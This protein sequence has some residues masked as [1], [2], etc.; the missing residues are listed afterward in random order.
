MPRPGTSPCPNAARVGAAETCAS[1]PLNATDTLPVLFNDSDGTVREKAARAMRRLRE[2]PEDEL[3][4]FIGTFVSSSAFSEHCEYLLDSLE[5]MTTLLPATA[6]AACVPLT[7][8]MHARCRRRR[9]WQHH[10]GPKPR[11]AGPDRNHPSPVSPRR[12][13]SSRPLP[14]RDRPAQRQQRVWARGRARTGALRSSSQWGGV[15]LD[16]IQNVCR[17]DP[18]GGQEVTPAGPLHRECPAQGL[19]VD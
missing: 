2:I 12:R 18:T 7:V 19:C 8:R 15:R 16:S 5:K 9:P 3:D 6:I 17:R 11:G 1:D 4:G 10:Y 14:G 13:S